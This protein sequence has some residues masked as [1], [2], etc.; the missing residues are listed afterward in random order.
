MFAWAAVGISVR[1]ERRAGIVA[2]VL[3]A[4]LVGIYGLTSETAPI[5]RVRWGESVIPERQAVVERAHSLVD[6]GSPMPDA[7]RSIAYVLLDTSRRNIEALVMNP[8]V[9]DTHD[10]D[11]EAFTIASTAG[12]SRRR[13]WLADR[14]PGLRSLQVQAAVV[15]ILA[16]VAA[17][18][19]ARPL[20]S[21]PPISA[22]RRWM[23]TDEDLFDRFG[24]SSRGAG[25][26]PG[27]T[28]RHDVSSALAKFAAAVL[29]VLSAGV[30]ILEG[31]KALLVASAILAIGFGT[32]PVSRRRMAVAAA[33]VLT[34][35]GLKA[36]LPR[37]DIAEGHNAFLV[38]RDGE[39]LER[40]LPPTIFRSWRQ[41]F[42][43]VYPPEPE[44]YIPN[45]WR[46]AGAVPTALFAESADAIWR[47]PKFTR[48][49]DAID[50]H[51][52]PTFRGGF[53]NDPRYNFWE[54]DLSRRWL[55]FY[56]MYEL[57]PASVGSRLTWT[58]QV[59][60][61]RA[62]GH[63]D[64]L[65]H[66]RRAGRLIAPE[67]AGR[68]VYAAWFPRPSLAFGVRLEPSTRLRFWG[69]AAMLLSIAGIFSVTSVMVRP[70]WGS[71]LRAL[72]LFMAGYALAL[73][74]SF[75][76]YLGG[77]YAPQAGGGDGMSHDAFGRTMAM[78]A[79]RGELLE[80]LRGGEP[81]YWLTPGTRYL[82]MVEKLLFGD[83]NHLFALIIACIPVIVF[84]LIRRFIRTPMAWVMTAVFLV[85][86]V[87]NLSFPHYV[88]N[89]TSGYGDAAGVA[90]FLFGLTILLRMQVGWGGGGGSLAAAASA[91]AALAAATF[92]RPNF[93]LAAVWVGIA[94]GWVFWRRR[95]IVRL[96][97]LVLGLG[98]ACW[99]PFHNWYYGGA[100]Y[101]ISRSASVAVPLGIGDYAHALSD[102]LQGRLSSPAAETVSAQIQGWLL[103]PGFAYRPWM[104]P[105]AWVAHAVKLA[106][107]IAACWV[108]CRWIAARFATGTDLAVMAVAALLAHAPMLVIFDTD[109]RYAM[110]GWDLS[111]LVLI[112]S[113]FRMGRAAEAPAPAPP[114]LLAYAPTAPEARTRP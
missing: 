32:G 112:G 88:T 39:A 21:S 19:L 65:V 61:E 3:L 98:I 48:Q 17:A 105:L 28:W 76:G 7:P 49:V 52:L 43:A 11:R 74:F 79:G 5:V 92:I 93:A 26:V 16:L 60:W 72:S 14:V 40:G 59:F 10:I 20:M 50:F 31:W 91:G 46:D 33:V 107:L 58:G 64:E 38:L 70:A 67:D 101:L 18:G 4:F 1:L 6:G 84:Y 85:L 104:Q 9:A 35:G 87:G 103:D 77:Q 30:P 66:E 63:F 13:I 75:D 24:A 8:D 81:V 47:R 56:A 69:W 97:A 106:G 54:G 37:A 45:S 23:G 41:Q 68:R 110:L 113:L 94:C 2:L 109:Y 102:V 71:Y 57:T 55:P 29:V 34:V 42:E 73:A 95:Q 90:F 111:L 78:L 86:P 27:R 62:D 36:L 80:A 108:V 53:V 83:T 12:R 96:V 25:T 99:M 89:A 22:L 100:F 114:S 51:T 82:R 44:P 15:L